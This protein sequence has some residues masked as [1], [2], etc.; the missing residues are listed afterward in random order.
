MKLPTSAVIPIEVIAAYLGHK[1]EVCPLHMAFGPEVDRRKFCGFEVVIQVP[2]EVSLR[3][4]LKYSRG[5][6]LSDAVLMGLYYPR[7]EAV[8]AMVDLFRPACEQFNG[9]RVRVGKK[10]VPGILKS[11]EV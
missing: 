11:L 10:E 1:I 7:Q 3:N 6:S 2:V 4:C 8:E 9:M 5:V